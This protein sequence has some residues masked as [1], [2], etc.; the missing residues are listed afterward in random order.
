MPNLGHFGPC[1]VGN[2]PAIVVDFSPPPTRALAAMFEWPEPYVSGSHATPEERRL[3]MNSLLSSFGVS[4]SL[5]FIWRAVLA[6]SIPA[7][8]KT[9]ASD[10]VFLANSFVSLYPALT[11][12][13]LAIAA[14]R[15]LPWG[16]TSAAM[17][18]AADENAYR[19]VG[20]S[21]GYM[22]YDC[23]YCLWHKEVRSPLIL[24]H[25]L[26]PMFSWPF[27]TFRHRAVIFV[28]YFVT[29]ELTNIGQ[30]LRM[31]MLK[32]GYDSTQLYQVIGVWWVVVFGLV[33]V[34]PAPFLFYQLFNGNYSAF[35][36]AEFWLTVTFV[37]LPFVLNA[38]WF[39]LLV[40]SVAKYYRQ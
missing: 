22:A 33:R 27:A 2:V 40:T 7:Y 8:R 30:H 39:Y 13:F 4:V 31:L 6:P 14:M 38:F 28:L 16:D 21:C 35:S 9:S 34:L 24:T 37:P 5:L 12:P 29:T 10:R 15:H 17:A 3:L 1:Q 26:L 32:L 25:H 19:A 36:A 23:L 11:A 20:I 18:A